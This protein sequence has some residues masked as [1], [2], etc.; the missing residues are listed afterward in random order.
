MTNLI[1]GIA[2]AVIF[3]FGAVVFAICFKHTRIECRIEQKNES[4]CPMESYTFRGE[5]SA[6]RLYQTG[7]IVYHHG[8]LYCWDGNNFIFIGVD[9]VRIRRLAQKLIAEEGENL[10]NQ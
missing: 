9:N 7:D 2:L 8:E 5:Y 4:I 6:S 10:F 1:P 3:L